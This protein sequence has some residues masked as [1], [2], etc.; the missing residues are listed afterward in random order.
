[1]SDARRKPPDRN[2]TI[3][4]HH[5]QMVVSVFLA[6]FILHRLPF[7]YIRRCA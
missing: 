7:R 3:G 1:V 2:Q 6:K 5:L 4:M